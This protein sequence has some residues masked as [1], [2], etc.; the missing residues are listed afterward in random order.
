MTPIVQSYVGIIL[1]G[2]L[3]ILEEFA[4]EFIS[5]TKGWHHPNS[6]RV[7]LTAMKQTLRLPTPSLVPP[8]LE[9]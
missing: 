2:C 1:S 6:S 8:H 4:H 9:K 5:T 7:I 3:T